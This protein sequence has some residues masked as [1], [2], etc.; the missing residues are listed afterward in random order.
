MSMCVSKTASVDAGLVYA[1]PASFVSNHAKHCFGFFKPVEEFGLTEMYRCKN[2][3][4]HY[5]K[6]WIARN[7]FRFTGLL[8]NRK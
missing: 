2:C 8:V 1:D 5:T 7:E 6:T 4:S 3:G